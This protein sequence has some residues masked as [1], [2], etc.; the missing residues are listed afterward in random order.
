MDEGEGRLLLPRGGGGESICRRPI[1]GCSCLL[2]LLLLVR[3]KG[4]VCNNCVVPRQSC[5]R[6]FTV[7]MTVLL[8]M[9]QS[10]GVSA[11]GPIES[12]AAALVGGVSGR[13]R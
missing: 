9:C 8:A 1:L 10:A 6:R 3:W 12:S 11:D 2:L 5:H 13:L 7:Y 4:L